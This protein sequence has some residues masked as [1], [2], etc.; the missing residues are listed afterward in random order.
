LLAFAAQALTNQLGSWIVNGKSSP[1]SP[2]LFAVLLGVTWRNVVGVGRRVERGLKWIIERLL[3]VGIALVGLRLTLQGLTTA[4]VAALPVVVACMLVATVTSLFVGRLLAIPPRLR[5]LLAAGTA[6]CG[7]TAIVAIAP[8]LRARHVETAIALMCVVA[9]GCSAMLVYPWL[10]SVVFGSAALPAGIFLGT[11]IHDTSQVVGSSLIFAQQFDAPDAVAVAGVTKFI[12][13]LGILIAVPLAAQWCRDDHE[14][15]DAKVRWSRALI[16]PTFVIWFAL[17]VI[18]RTVGDK[19]V[20]LSA[21]IEPLWPLALRA[22]QSASE[23]FLVCGMTAVGLGIPL[24]Q[25]QQA[26]GR[27]LF[28]ALLIAAVTGTC[29]LLLTYALVFGHS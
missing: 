6:I 4:G 7:C 3:R 5:Q 12:R 24:S 26:G 15:A 22:A 10:A 21:F 9:I 29:S 1:L 19:T 11:S 23:L 16:F 25:L 14:L 28:A 18:V 8:V 2:M 17:L 20:G 27:P 13:N